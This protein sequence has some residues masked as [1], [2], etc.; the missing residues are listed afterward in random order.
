MQETGASEDA[1][2]GL[3]SGRHRSKYAMMATVIVT[4]LTAMMIFRG[5]QSRIRKRIGLPPF[6]VFPLSCQGS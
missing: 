4:A 6:F 2:A 3:T 5:E 1:P